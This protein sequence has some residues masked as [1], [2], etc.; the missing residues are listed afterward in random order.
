MIPTGYQVQF[1]LL[2]L[3]IN[4][5]DYQSSVGALKIWLHYCVVN[6]D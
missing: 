5:F 2:E 4:A 1:K 3:V 6:L